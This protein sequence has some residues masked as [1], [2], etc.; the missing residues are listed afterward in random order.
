[1][2]HISR[3]SSV[4]F[5]GTVFTAAAAYLFKV[6][7]AR[8]LGAEA[9]GVYALGMTIVGLV[10]AFNALGLPQSAIRFVAA[11]SVTGKVKLL[12]GFLYRSFFLLLVSNLLLG[13]IL[14][15]AGR[16]IA[17]HIYHTPALS[18]YMGLFAL[19]MVSGTMNLFFGQV[20]TGYKDVAKRTIITNFIGTPA[21]M[22]LTILLVAWGFGLW[23]Y[24]SAQVASAVLTMVLLTAVAWKLTPK[25]A[26]APS[27]WKVP[28]EQEVVSFSM[29]S[30]GMIFLQFLMGQTDK[31]LIGFYL[32][33]REV[34]IYAV[35]MG[36][37]A[38]VPSVL[39]AVNQIFAP[40]IAE[41]HARGDYE[42]LRRI[43]QTLTK[44]VLGLT[45][46]L[47]IMLLIFARPFMRIFGH[48]FEIGWS[49]LIIGTLGEL[50]DCAVGSVGFLLLMSGNERRLLRIQTITVAGTVI[51]NLLLIPRLGIV[52]AAVASG[53]TNIVT[54][55]WCL[56]VVHK[57]LALSPYTRSY[58]R[59][60]APVTGSLTVL[61]LARSALH[62]FRPLFVMGASLILAYA[63]FG[64]IALLFG[65]DADDQLIANAV[66]A[67][68]R[69]AVPG[70]R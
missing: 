12:G 26:R 27:L 32:N 28:F 17:V 61:L 22:V 10:S 40:T 48:D 43:F 13:G 58:L 30:F 11:Y 68:F 44:W 5:L 25:Q 21:M 54:N 20:L 9:L 34:G 59:L 29:A 69:A 45:L 52:G 31:I 51:L 2:G 67:R 53:V 60:L 41:L 63:V 16:W 46:P 23:G 47:I 42:L 38:F 50:I 14:V 24:I 49:V 36:L 62:A 1:M 57:I 6:Y 56:R 19:I 65:L 37:V 35:A 64:A 33:A 18:T 15:A 7:L 39:Q 8:T 3:Q 4:F 70:A 66:W 55:L